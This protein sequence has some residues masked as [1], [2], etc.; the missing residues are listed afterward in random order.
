[1][2]P[3][4][5]AERTRQQAL[6][7]AGGS[8]QFFRKQRLQVA[9]DLIQA[10][11]QVSVQAVGEVLVRMNQK[12][13]PSQVQAMMMGLKLVEKEADEDHDDLPYH[14]DDDDGQSGQEGEVETPTVDLSAINATSAHLLSARALIKTPFV[15]LFVPQGI[16]YGGLDTAEEQL[17]QILSLDNTSVPVVWGN[18]NTRPK[19]YVPALL[20]AEQAGRPVQFVAWGTP[21]LPRVSRLEL[22]RRTVAKFRNTGRYIPAGAVGASL[23]RVEALIKE[24]EKEKV[25]LFQNTTTLFN[26]GGNSTLKDADHQ[27]NVALA[28]LAGFRMD[29]EGFVTKIGKP[30]TRSGK[31]TISNNSS[32]SSS[33]ENNRPIERTEN[34]RR[35]I[36]I[37]GGDK[38][39][40]TPISYSKGER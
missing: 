10:V 12:Q 7:Q 15:E 33:K 36:R 16:F 1:M 13:N 21:N 20:A 22:L 2:T 25:A 6:K 24:A 8:N 3:E 39:E 18:T 27:M 34:Q 32:S 40:K 19:E 37:Q 28:S 14:D 38:M 9:E 30:K 23:G 31:Q 11:E 26:N 4:E 17:Q 5:F 29:S 35:D